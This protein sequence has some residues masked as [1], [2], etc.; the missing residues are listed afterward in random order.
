MNTN[1]TYKLQVNGSFAAT[2]KSFLIKH[3]TKP[4][5]HLQHGA[6]EGPEHGVYVRGRIS[7]QNIITLPDYWWNLVDE[8]TITIQLTPIGK[9]QKLYIVKSDSHSVHIQSENADSIDC[10]YFI[11]AER[12][13][14][15]KMETEI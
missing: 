13:D 5:K 8:S 1:T 12:K 4:G 7:N 9:F 11:Q 15:R 6:L 2:S 10:Y 3:P 14:I